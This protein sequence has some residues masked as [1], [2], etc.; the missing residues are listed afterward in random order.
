M[1]ARAALRGRLFFLP[2]RM[3]LRAFPPVPTA[4]LP[5]LHPIRPV[6]LLP[7]GADCNPLSKGV[8][9]QRL[10]RAWRVSSDIPTKPGDPLA[11]V[12]G[13]LGSIPLEAVGSYNYSIKLDGE[14]DHATYNIHSE[15][16]D[17]VGIG[18]GLVASAYV[19]T[20]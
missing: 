8:R 13:P 9:F 6:G 17:T 11:W 4:C 15:Q 3:G 16:H 14:E 10:T 12:S 20:K 7:A 1:L 19:C 2:S 18:Y 5:R